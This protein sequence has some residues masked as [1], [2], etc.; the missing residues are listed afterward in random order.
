MLSAGYSYTNARTR[1]V[2]GN[3]YLSADAANGTQFIHIP[4]NTLF[5]F[6]NYT[7]HRVLGTL[8]SALFFVWFVSGL[9][10]IYHTFPK[11]TGQEKIA[12]LYPLAAQGL[13]LDSILVRVPYAGAASGHN[14]APENV[15][16]KHI[17]SI[18]LENNLGQET[19][20]VSAGD[21]KYNFNRN[22]TALIPDSIPDRILNRAALWGGGPVAAIDTLYKLEQWIPFGQLKRHQW[23]DVA[24]RY[25]KMVCSRA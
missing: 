22:L 15:L 13:L 6:A 23:D 9:V 25:S 20:Y 18:T 16:E 24:L 10:M 3:K 5:A 11:I 17:T 7:M 4:E 19:F 2:N 21:T 14:I 1:E 8:L 12:K